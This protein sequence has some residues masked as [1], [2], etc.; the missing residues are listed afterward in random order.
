MGE[1]QKGVQKLGV[2]RELVWTLWWGE[3][4]L[5][6]HSSFWSHDASNGTFSLSDLA[7]ILAEE[8]KKKK[9]RG[10]NYKEEKKKTSAS[11]PHTKN[12]KQKT[13]EFIYT[14]MDL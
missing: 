8:K 6:I 12:T 13:F 14:Q 10:K 9:K 3:R 5:Q 1:A 7:C 11:Y 4:G 2:P